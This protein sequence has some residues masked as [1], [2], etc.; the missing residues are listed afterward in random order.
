M[1]GEAQLQ[2]LGNA[3]GTVDEDGRR[4]RWAGLDRRGLEQRQPA[5]EMCRREFGQLRMRLHRRALVAARHQRHR[6]P[7]GAELV[8]MRIP[9]LDGA[10]EDRS[11]QRVEAYAGVE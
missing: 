10:V 11:E 7:E 3:V 2:G 6:R 5:L 1:Q 8:E 4:I 9:I